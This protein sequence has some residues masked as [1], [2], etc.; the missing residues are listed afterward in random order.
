VD[1]VAPDGG[2]YVVQVEFTDFADSMQRAR[3][4]VNL[5]VAGG[6]P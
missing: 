3:K 4:I 6:I 2:R 5:L 1:V